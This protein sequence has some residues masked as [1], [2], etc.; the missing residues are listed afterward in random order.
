[1][2]FRHKNWRYAFKSDVI[3]KQKSW[4]YSVCNIKGKWIADM[5][6]QELLDFW[7]EKEVDNHLGKQQ[8]LE[9]DIIEAILQSYNVKIEEWGLM[10]FIEK[11]F[12]EE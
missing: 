5:T 8:D 7:F 11:Y 4:E 10:F 6:E 9:K 12:P 3:D 2:I 1:M